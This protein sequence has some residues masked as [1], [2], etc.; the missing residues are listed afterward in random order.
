M[1][2]RDQAALASS[3]SA[4]LVKAKSARNRPSFFACSTIVSSLRAAGQEG[5]SL[6]RRPDLDREPCRDRCAA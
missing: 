5:P 2:R 1:S 3:T 4:T 6:A